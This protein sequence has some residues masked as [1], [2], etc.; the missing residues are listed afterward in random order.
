MSEVKVVLNGNGIR[1]LLKSEEVMDICR[2]HANKALGKLGDGYEVTTMT[3]VNRV[4]ASICARSRKAK[5][6]NSENN[7]IMKA[8]RG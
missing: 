4:N 1:E 3:G 8:L 2:N 5:K 6:E 7:T